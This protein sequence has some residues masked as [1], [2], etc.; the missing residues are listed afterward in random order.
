MLSLLA[1]T[2]MTL[3]FDTGHPDSYPEDAQG[4]HPKSVPIDQD[5]NDQLSRQERMKPQPLPRDHPALH[6]RQ[7]PSKTRDALQKLFQEAQLLLTAKDAFVGAYGLDAAD[8]DLVKDVAAAA[9]KVLTA[10]WNEPAGSAV[11]RKGYDE[12][13][14]A[15]NSIPSWLKYVEKRKAIKVAGAVREEL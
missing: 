3:A 5:K 9:H 2:L 12:M 8:L 10:N 13:Q 4:L 15:L 1:L 11:F 7:Q 14:L 6:Q